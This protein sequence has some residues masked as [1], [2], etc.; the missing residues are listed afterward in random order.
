MLQSFNKGHVNYREIVRT[1]HTDFEKA[2]NEIN[3]TK[4][5]EPFENL[6]MSGNL[7]G[8]LGERTQKKCHNGNISSKCDASSVSQESNSRP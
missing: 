2:F 1:G 8:S 7:P 3:D 4:S 6:W 5:I